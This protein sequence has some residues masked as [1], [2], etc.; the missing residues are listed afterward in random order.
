MG[1]ESCVVLEH[2][3]S[4]IPL[5]PK[6]HPPHPIL[7]PTSVK[8]L[9]PR[10]ETGSA[11]NISILLENNTSLHR[12]FHLL[13]NHVA[14]AI[15]SAVTSLSLSLTACGSTRPAPRRSQRR[16]R[17]QRAPYLTP[18]ESTSQS[19]KV[20]PFY[21]KTTYYY[22]SPPSSPNPIKRSLSA[23]PTNS[24]YES[25]HRS[26][27]PAPLPSALKSPTSAKMPHALRQAHFGPVLATYSRLPR[28]DEAYVMKAYS[29]HISHCERCLPPSH[30]CS[31]GQSRA[32]DVTQ[33][34]FGSSGNAISVVDLDGDR[35]MEVEI[36]PGCEP[37]RVL[38][39]AMERGTLRLKNSS[40]SGGKEKKERKAMSYDET[41]YVAPRRAPSS[42]SHASRDLEYDLER[43]SHSS[44]SSRDR[45][46]RYITKPR[47][48]TAEPPPR[49]K[50][51]SRTTSERRPYSVVERRPTTYY[52]VGSRGKLPVPAKDDWY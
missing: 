30:L 17:A 38:L 23:P 35:R 51:L 32:L 28:D 27:D 16:H 46:L 40:R 10:R 39:K 21:T 5:L 18:T 42:R 29:R 47:L 3:S 37:V 52:G 45:P 50:G 36:P 2:K 43:A 22:P 4:S 33:Y 19:V 44:H 13:H 12:C 25:G 26:A 6:T 20:S 8:P 49:T 9:P 11:P 1:L 31:K 7:Q 15:L 48:E 24:P 41:Y 34:I 14:K